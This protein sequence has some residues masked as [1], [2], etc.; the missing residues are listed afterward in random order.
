MVKFVYPENVCKGKVAN[1]TGT[2]TVITV[3]PE[4]FSKT[5]MKFTIIT[6]KQRVRSKENQFFMITS[7]VT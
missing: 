5:D 1:I 4:T 2:Y 6:G 3:K 7:H